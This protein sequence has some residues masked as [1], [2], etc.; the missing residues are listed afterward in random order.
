M[1]IPDGFLNVHGEEVVS[2]V[3]RHR[4]P[5]VYPFRLFTRIGG[6][7]S[8]GNDQ[9]DNYRRSAVYADKILN[10]TQ[11]SD[12]PVQAPVKIRSCHQFDGRQGAWP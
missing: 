4:L 12:L 11:P 6:L 9:R 8:Y 1:V 2:L 7:L 10:G 5:T 3:A